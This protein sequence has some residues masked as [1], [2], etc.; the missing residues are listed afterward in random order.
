MALVLSLICPLS[1]GS[2]DLKNPWGFWDWSESVFSRKMPYFKSISKADSQLIPSQQKNH[3]PS[4]FSFL[5]YLF[6]LP[7]ISY[8]LMHIEIFLSV[9]FCGQFLVKG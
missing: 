6:Y 2:S 4:T 9:P 5:C 8:T 7:A 3:L 1:Q